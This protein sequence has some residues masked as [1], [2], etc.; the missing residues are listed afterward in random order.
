MTQRMETSHDMKLLQDA[1]DWMNESDEPT[2]DEMLQDIAAR[3]GYSKDDLDKPDVLGAILAEIMPKQDAVE[4]LRD[5]M[6]D[7]IEYVQSYYAG[8]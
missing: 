3:N 5:M 2:L 7:N 8:L 4:M 6:H 1:D